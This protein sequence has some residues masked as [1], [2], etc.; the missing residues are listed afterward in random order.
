MSEQQP[1]KLQDPRMRILI[2]AVVIVGLVVGGIFIWRSKSGDVQSQGAASVSSAPALQSLPGI[3]KSSNE[4]VKDQNIQNRNEA[5]KA[6]KEGKSSVPTITRPNF[7]GNPDSFGTLDQPKTATKK[8][9]PKVCAIKKVVVMY[10]PNPAACTVDNLK[11]ARSAGVTAE[12]LACQSCS[13]E[14]LRAAGY[15]AGEMKGVGYSADKLKQCGYSL[16]QL[17]S[18]G[19]SA[20]DLK[21]AGFSANQLKKAG[22]TAGQLA[23]AGYSANDLRKAGYSAAAIKAAGLSNGRCSVEALEKARKEGVSAKAL[24]AEGCGAAAMKAAG[25][26]AKQLKDAGFSA[27]QLKAAGY[28]A[29]QLKNAGYSADALKAAGFSDKALKK[30]GYTPAEIAAANAKHKNCSV[31]YLKRARASGVSAQDLKNQGCGLAALKAAG[32]TA[33]QLK[34]AGYSAK[35]LKDAGFSAKQLKDAGFSAKAL[36]DAGFSAKALKKA[37]FSAKDL[38]NAGYTP[39]ELK[40]AGYSAQALKDAGF[41]VKQLKDAGYSA[42]A[43]KDAGYS[44]K[45]L[46]AAGYNAGQLKD[47][48][49]SAKALKN[50]GFN[51]KQ[52]HDAG[53]TAKALKNA[54]YS[55]AALKAAGYSKGDLLRAGYSAKQAGYDTAPAQ[56]QTV[57]KT[58]TPVA[59][60]NFAGSVIDPNSAAAR[61]AKFE[62]W[63]ARQMN[64]Q[65]R[66]DS[67]QRQSSAMAVEAQKMLSGWS[68]NA[69]Q[70]FVKGVETKPATTGASALASGALSGQ[71]SG[72][73]KTG[74]DTEV[75]KAGTVMFAVLDTSINTDEKTPIMAR[76]VTG[77]LKGAKLLGKFERVNKKVLLT[78]SLLN[79]PSLDT[80]LKI[81]TVAID[82]DTARTAV[83]GTVNN[84]YL[85]RYGTL[86]ASAFISGLADSLKSANTT[87]L[88]SLLGPVVIQKPLNTTQSGLVALGKVGDRYSSVMEKNFYTPPT[89]KIPAGTGLGIL[90]MSDVGVPKAA[91][92]SKKKDL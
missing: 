58:T 44:A 90:F 26:T 2:A 57:A 59:K 38:K 56:T 1:N 10:K 55:P 35:Q 3:G 86:F 62:K 54:G 72:N 11:R 19:Y 82:P 64:A 14:S 60:H 6:R 23:D 40:K 32:Y 36:K 71:K 45:A 48:G 5:I 91:I 13:C 22:F 31:E 28:N 47:A 79:S 15:S 16:S 29:K 73:Q 75:I 24:K 8:S 43:L 39:S 21:A 53:Y 51:A 84:H 18:A 61:L 46:K 12:E 85:L 52:L 80:S 33:A 87:T 81:N 63:Q 65:Q 83:G 70:T 89:V 37:G 76:V 68:N 49:F 27:A 34:A 77:P 88:P 9:K 69:S 7:I 66:I 50:A 30:A 25:F 92:D 4:Y 20:K 67:M 17:V 74:A 78:F 42:K 41:S